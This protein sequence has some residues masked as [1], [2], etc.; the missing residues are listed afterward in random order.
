[1]TPATERGVMSRIARGGS[2]SLAGSGVSALA[3]FVVVV[4]VTRAYDTA[5][6][7][8]LFAATSVFLIALALAQLGADTGVVRFLSWEEALGRRMQLKTLMRVAFAPVAAIAGVVVIAL[9]AGAG[10]I[11]TWISAPGESREIAQLVLLF[12][13]FVP[14]GAAYQM[15]LAAT[16]GL[17]TM[18]PTV[19]I[20]RIGRPLMQL[21]LVSLAALEGAKPL[22]L[23]LAWVAP[24][25]IGL[26][27][28]FGSLV[29][30]F[31]SQPRP[32]ELT[33]TPGPS[34]GA[35]WR[36]SAARGA[37]TAL[38]VALQRVDIVLVAALA[39]PEA[40]ALYT[41]ATR[42]LV[43][44]QLAVSAI[45]Q[46][47]DP[48]LARLVA[49]GERVLA[50]TVFRKITA[51]FVALVWPV[52]ITT[53]VFSGWLLGLFGEAYDAAA[54]S[55]TVL[56]VAMLFATA[57]G[58]LDSLLLMGGYSGLSLINMIIAL[59]I[60]I[61]LC[62]LLVPDHGALGA[63]SAW[64]A[65]IVARN[66]LSWFQVARL[67]HHDGRSP[68]LALVA[69]ASLACFGG[70]G[71]I[72]NRAID[73]PLSL[74]VTLGIGCTMYSLVLWHYRESLGLTALVDVLRRSPAEALT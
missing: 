52:Y 54:I 56:C 65:A 14:I 16:R 40:A 26:I 44:G 62:F 17:G 20:E 64:A 13:L 36:F 39:G 8:S 43:V 30:L 72:A 21:L 4:V 32:G 29:R 24:Y 7:G 60:D 38:Q 42:F 58:P 35:F 61:A 49:S 48:Q 41:A 47:V 31:R 5:T 18:R 50:A 73:A 46:A 12:C 74:T 51:W 63:A 71:L 11:A 33:T 37:A 67:Y 70:L 68:M 15:A 23:G 55:L 69:G 9:A 6:A 45:Q 25:A 28:S 59:A 34:L 66:V 1:M 2:A 3:G 53:A 19:L 57:A 27:P 22:L 10:T